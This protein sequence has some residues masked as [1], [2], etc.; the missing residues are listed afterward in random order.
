[1]SDEPPRAAGRTA[2]P[3]LLLG[4]A[5]LLTGCGGQDKGAHAGASPAGGTEKLPQATTYTTLND[6]PRDAAPS[7]KGDGTVVHPNDTVPVSAKPGAP[8]MAELPSTQLKGPTWVPVLESRPGWRRVLLPSRPNGVTGWIPDSG[9]KAARS[10]S[11]IK[12]DLGDRK[13]TLTRAG[14]K[15][16]TWPVAVGAPKTPTP[17]GRTFLLASLAPEKPT[18]SPLILPVGAHSATLDTFGGGPGTVAF[19]GWPSK[20]VFGKAVTHGCVRVPAGALKQ[21][22]KVPLGTSVQITD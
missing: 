14:R 8:A 13:L 2:A 1:M 9:L 16:G 3:A 21:L 22:S 5:L 17:T 12:V 6:L 7:A 18:Y 4:A 11:A 15:V 20:S 19:H 10:T